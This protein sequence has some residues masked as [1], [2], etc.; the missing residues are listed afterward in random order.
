M[1]LE[2]VLQLGAASTA[3]LPGQSGRVDHAVVG[4][5]GG[6]PAVLFRGAGEGL[7][8]DS[9]ADAG[10]GRQVQAVAGVV[11]QPGDDLGSCTVGQPVVGEVGL[12]AFVGP[13][14]LE[15]PVGRLGS[16][17]R[18]RFDLSGSDQDPVNGGA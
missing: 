14:G 13:L 11:I 16:F 6:W 4:E 17:G 3:A 18:L 10:V 15:A 2:Q 8:G 12:P 9:G 1:V 7:C 5:G